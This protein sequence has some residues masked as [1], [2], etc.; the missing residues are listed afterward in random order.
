MKI[1]SIEI[2]NVR[3]IEHIKIEMRDLLALIGP[4]NA[5][6]SNIMKAIKLFL[7]YD[8]PSDEDF[9]YRRRDKNIEIKV[10]LE[11]NDL[12]K[13]SSKSSADGNKLEL[14]RQITYDT[15]N[16]LSSPLQTREGSNYKDK[17]FLLPK[18]IYIPAVK[19][20]SEETVVKKTNPFGEL[21][22]LVYKSMTNTKE[23]RDELI[24]I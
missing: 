17:K 22:N 23:I 14:I 6:K 10:E 11:L 16:S 2:L 24:E 4:N 20:I 15:K 1:R 12:E 7:E 5:G 18:L 8:K 3:S 19:H 9:Y 13:G 21:I